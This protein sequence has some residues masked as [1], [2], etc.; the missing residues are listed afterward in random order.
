MSTAGAGSGAPLPA[1]DITVF[2]PGADGFTDGQYIWVREDIVQQHPDLRGRRDSN[3][4][5]TLPLPASSVALTQTP[6]VP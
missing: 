1:L 2:P 5:C 4:L 3:P 6:G